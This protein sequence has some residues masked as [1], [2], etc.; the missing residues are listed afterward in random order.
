MRA[1]LLAVLAATSSPSFAREAYHLEHIM[2]LQPE[3]VL[4]ERIPGVQQVTDYI[5][6]VGAAADRS[7]AAEPKPYE[8]AGFIAVAVR[9]GGLSKV[10][11]D[12]SPTL[13]AD[14]EA[15]LRQ[16]LESV[17][18]FAARNGVVVFALNV[19]LWGSPPTG[20]GSPAPTA[21]QDA[22]AGGAEPLEIGALVDKVW[23]SGGPGHE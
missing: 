7:L 12:I 17:P 1:F 20:P 21:W 15:R 18:A 11:F 10:W 2:L 16:A 19:T 14:V 9:P 8:S 5:K 13:P 6:A 23:P 3:S 4:S 22:M